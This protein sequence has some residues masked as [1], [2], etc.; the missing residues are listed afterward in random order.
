MPAVGIL[1]ELAA[2]ALMFF[3][4]ALAL[5]GKQIVESLQRALAGVPVIGGAIAAILSPV[6]HALAWAAGQI[7][8]GVDAVVGASLHLMAKT[9]E[10]YWHQWVQA[11]RTLWMVAKVAAHALHLHAG[12]S[13]LVHLVERTVHGIEHGVRDLRRLW[14]G[15]EH[16]V[17]NLERSLG[18]GIG[19]DVITQLHAL[20]HEWGRFRTKELPGIEAGVQGIPKDI[21]DL[22]TWAE[23]QF[24][25]NTDTALATAV[26]VGLGALGLGGLR[27][28][29]N[30]FRNNRGACGLWGDLSDILGLAIFAATALDFETLVHEA[31]DAAE[32]TTVAVKDVFG[33]G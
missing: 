27:C 13:A 1:P 2:L 8:R 23:G 19:H 21:A 25:S 24:V 32:V 7:E 14:H 9:V 28:D 10:W 16:R 15:I 4:L 29:S 12:V 20:Q 5:S 30:P 6:V 17:K 31:Q 18:Q 11:T 33:L 22:K 26:A 3:A